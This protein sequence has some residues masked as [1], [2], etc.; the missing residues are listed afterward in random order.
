MQ[1]ETMHEGSNAV[2]RVDLQ[3]GEKFKA[4]AGAMVAKSQHLS[5]KGHMWGGV[6]GAFKRS[7]LGGE[8]FFFQEITATTGDGDII[9]APSVPGDIKILPMRNSEDYYIQNGCMLAGL[10]DIEMDTRVQKLTAGVFSGA[11]FFVLH[12]RGHGEVAVAAFGA[13]MEIH[14]PAGKEY[15]VDNGHVVAWS[16]DLEYQIVKAG[17]N[18]ISSFTSGEG[19]AC[20][21]TGPGKVWIQTRNP[22]GFGAWVRRFVPSRG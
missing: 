3:R 7:F 1:Y 20:K 22:K 2:L 12:V 11:G 14:I 15:I 17:A 10:G 4:E 9:I 8:S 5:I 6:F 21:F 13:I 18:W 19:L 16:G